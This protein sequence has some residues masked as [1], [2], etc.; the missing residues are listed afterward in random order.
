MKKLVLVAALVASVAVAGCET[1]QAAGTVTG[2]S[3]A[4]SS[5]ISSEAAADR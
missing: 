2:P 3:S 5:A 1:N 4:A